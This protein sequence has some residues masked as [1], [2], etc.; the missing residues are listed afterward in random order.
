MIELRHVSD[1]SVAAASGLVRHWDRLFVVAD[2]SA[3]IAIHSER[4]EQV[5]TIALDG[6]TA[7][8]PKAEKPDLESLALAPDGFL[9][10]IGSGSTDRRERGW[11]WR[12]GVD[13]VEFS[14]SELYAAL[15]RE[16]DDLNIEG[17]A[18]TGDRAWLAQ[19]GN[20]ANGRNALVELVTKVPGTFVTDAVVA[21]RD[22]DLGDACGVPLTFSDLAPLPDGRLL[23]CAV[24]EAGESTYHDGD[25]VGSAIGVL[26]PGRGTIERVVALEGSPK[27]EGVTFVSSSSDLL[28]VA[29][30]D[31]PST[32]APLLAGRLDG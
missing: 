10:T 24:A 6:D 30:D 9:T 14:L 31:D 12:P 3:V 2:D 22:Y 21:I 28:F 4:G 13:P 16:L 11:C 27:V 18:F 20:G 1:L 17:L 29:D 8:R 23:F 32:P 7:P 15:R 5:D 19:R 26:D 25:C